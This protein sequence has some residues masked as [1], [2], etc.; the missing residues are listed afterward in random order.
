MLRRAGTYLG[1]S[2]LSEDAYDPAELLEAAKRRAE[3]L[4]SFEV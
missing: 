2:R 1:F 4:T 3:M